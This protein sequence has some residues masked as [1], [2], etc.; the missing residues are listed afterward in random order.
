MS[1]GCAEEQGAEGLKGKELE[2]GWVGAGDW[3]WG[4]WPSHTA[5][6]F[7]T[8]GEAGQEHGD[9]LPALT[10]SYRRSSEEP[11]CVCRSALTY[12]W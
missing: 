1:G 10:L 4:Q 2:L 3:G 12:R 11:V 5:V 7:L 6:P 9:A 8:L